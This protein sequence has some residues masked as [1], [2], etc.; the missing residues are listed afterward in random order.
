M[1]RNRFDQFIFDRF[2]GEVLPGEEEGGGLRV[3]QFS[4]RD[5]EFTGAELSGVFELFHG[6]P[7]H[8]DAEFGADFVRAKF[9][10]GGDLPRIPPA[11]YRLALHYRGDRLQGKIEGQKVAEQDRVADLETKTD[12]YTLLSADVSYRFLV[13]SSVI[14]LLV[15]GTNLTDELAR[16]HVSFVKDAA[17]LAG[18]DV[19]VGVRLSF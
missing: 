4:Q 12:G 13:G 2:T 3:L 17:P 7:H 14:D 6:E 15:R 11:R 19:T 16:N 5:A 8:W 1:F 18:R 9:T 10:R